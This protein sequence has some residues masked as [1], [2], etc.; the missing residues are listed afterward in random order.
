MTF[1]DDDRGASVQIG[2]ILLFAIIII[3]VSLWQAQVV[4]QQNASVEYAHNQRAQDDMKELRTALVS[5]PGERTVRSVSIDM[6]PAYPPRS[7]FVNPGPP[8]GTLRTVGTTNASLNVTVENATAVDDETADVWNG[9]PRAYNTGGIVYEPGYNVYTSAPDT[10]YENTVLY[11]VQDD[12]TAV[13]V[14]GQDV[15][16]GRTI[17]LVVLNGS[18]SRT[19]SDAYSVDFEALSSSERSVAVTNE[20]GGGH[21]NV[22]FASRRGEGWWTAA[23][24][25]SEEFVADGG[26]VVDVTATTLGNGFYNVSV[27]LEGDVTYE[28][29]MAKIGVGS[30]TD[31]TEKEYAVDVSGDGTSVQQGTTQQLVVEV[32]DAYNNPVSGVTVAN[33]TSGSDLL[34]G[35][36]DAESKT[37]DDE[38]RVTFEYTAP[39]GSTGTA[40]IQFN[41]SDDVT[42]R[43]SEL[44]NFS[45][46]VTG[47]GGGGGGGGA[48]SITWQDPDAVNP[49]GSL[50]SCDSDDCTW[51]VGADSDTALDLRAA[52][53]PTVE[54]L[55][56]S[57]HVNDSS[58]AT[59]SNSD[60]TTG[61]NGLANTTLNAQANGTVRV[62]VVGGSDSDDIN[63]TVTNFDPAVVYTGVGEGFEPDGNGVHSVLAFNVSN[64]R[65]G[66]VTLTAIKINSTSTG[67]DRIENGDSLS[68]EVLVDTDGDFVADGSTTDQNQI[69]IGSKVS[70]DTTAVL[71]SG[72]E[73][74][75]NVGEFSSGGGPNNEV[76]LVGESVTVTIYYEDASGN[77][78]AT[79]FT[80]SSVSDG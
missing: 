42:P 64:E 34:G 7:V 57:F 74:R 23:F 55:N 68:T 52:T 29:R 56:V 78:Y 50:S 51:D 72:E 14:S 39:A 15:V 22:S 47:S 45:V 30:G 19:T 12:G 21:V 76:D 25:A 3:A 77:S 71:A 80:I 65:P 18:L 4:P 33:N 38:G 16:D 44:V 75:W 62:F 37:T 2:A 41:I 31:E 73:A 54:D 69:K 49:S 53:D 58:V 26:H 70:L 17:T 28:L 32:R 61:S 11:N 48:Y 66:D 10:A 24:E 1:R 36:L 9:S 60:P 46:A 5:A 8:S 6:A 59:L 35:S 43:G 67:A 20:T 63:V 13:N 79:T 40:S 27:E